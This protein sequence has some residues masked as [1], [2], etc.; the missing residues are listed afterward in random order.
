MRRQSGEG[1]AFFRFSA[2]LVVR[3]FRLP[4]LDRQ[5]QSHRP[6]RTCER[7]FLLR[8]QPFTRQDWAQP[9]AAA[10]SYSRSPLRYRGWRLTGKPNR[11]GRVLP[12]VNF[13]DASM[14]NTSALI[15]AMALCLASPAFAAGGN[16][17]GGN[18]GATPPNTSTSAAE[19]SQNAVP[20]SYGV[21]P[22]TPTGSAN[23]SNHWVGQGPQM[24]TM[25]G[26]TVTGSVPTVNGQQTSA[27]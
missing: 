13:G 5:K 17:G 25:N 6:T 8:A 24:K 20:P 4:P 16:G 12:K 1:W 15:A 26:Q 18:G 27:Q 23:N 2:R 21:S 7:M 22:T 11:S 3:R 14:K 9:F 19:G 10:I